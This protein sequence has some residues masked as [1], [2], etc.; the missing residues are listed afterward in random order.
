VTYKT[1]D[2]DIIIEDIETGDQETL[3]SSTRVCDGPHTVR[4]SFNPAGIDFGNQAIARGASADL[5]VVDEIGQLEL[6]QEGLTK[7]LGLIEAEPF[8][9]C[10]VVIRRE[11]LDAYSPWLPPRALVFETTVDNRDH[12]P[13]DIASVLLR[14]KDAEP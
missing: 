14:E 4:Y 13:E 1:V 10:A 6:R 7:A 3:A 5:L 12:L 9:P 8:A 2:R 11:L